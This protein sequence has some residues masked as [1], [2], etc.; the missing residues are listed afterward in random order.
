MEAWST[1]ETDI[2]SFSL[3][4]SFKGGQFGEGLSGR[5]TRERGSNWDV[6]RIHYFYE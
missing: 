1:C 2:K 5:R 3:R 4:V 6:K